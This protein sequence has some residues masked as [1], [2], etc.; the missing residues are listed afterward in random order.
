MRKRT[1]RRKRRKGK[2]PVER[3]SLRQ[4]HGE[5]E[6]ERWNLRSVESGMSGGFKG[7]VKG[8]EGAERERKREKER[9]NEGEGK[10]E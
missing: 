9:K 10:R 5:R 8:T 1:M 2:S 6:K 7:T 3:D 4:G